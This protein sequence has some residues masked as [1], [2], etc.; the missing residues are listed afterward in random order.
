MKRHVVVKASSE[1]VRKVVKASRT[2]ADMLAAFED[3]L[4]ELEVNSATDPEKK[5]TCSDDIVDWLA[6]HD[7]AYADAV[8]YFGTDDLES[9]SQEELESW[10]GD[11]DQLWE[12]YRNFFGI[13]GCDAI[14]A[15][16]Y[17]AFLDN[18]VDVY[19]EDYHEKYVDV[20]GYFGEPG[21]IYSVADMKAYWN[22]DRDSDPVL[23]N[24]SS[25]ESWFRDTRDNFL[26]EA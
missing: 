5:I 23:S 7:Q 15:T 3:K 20:G 13:E 6:E 18:Q 1:P 16:E 14:Q 24:Y 4:E 10:I 2:T 22:T 9:V 11:H 25:F 12:D 26:Q 19:G 21:E 17:P 8:E